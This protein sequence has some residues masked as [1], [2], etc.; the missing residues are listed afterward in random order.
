MN[1][2]AVNFADTEATF[3]SIIPL[4]RSSDPI[5]ASLL[6]HQQATK[7]AQRRPILQITEHTPQ[8]QQQ[9]DS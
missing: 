2:S 5:A 3:V 6:A 1:R 8:S 9:A 7:A 4:P